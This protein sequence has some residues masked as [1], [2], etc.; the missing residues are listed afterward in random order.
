MEHDGLIV[1]EEVW[2][3]PSLEIVVAPNEKVWTLV[4]LGDGHGTATLYIDVIDVEAEVMDSF[5]LILSLVEL[6]IDRLSFKQAK[7]KDW[8]LSLSQF[9]IVAELSLTIITPDEKSFLGSD[10]TRV[11]HTSRNFSDFALELDRLCVLVVTQVIR[12]KSEL[13][14]TPCAPTVHFH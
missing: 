4:D 11:D 3:A 13:T 5:V 1:F 9:L 6:G 14:L 2:E 10:G 12:T 8:F 7:E